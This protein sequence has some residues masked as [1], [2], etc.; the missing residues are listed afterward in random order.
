[1]IRLKVELDPRREC[2]VLPIAYNII[3]EK[4]AALLI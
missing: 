2:S 3:V 1:M 4:K